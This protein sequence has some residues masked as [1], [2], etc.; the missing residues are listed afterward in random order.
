VQ[1][2]PV[3]CVAATRTCFRARPVARQSHE[4]RSAARG[5]ASATMAWCVPTCPAATHK[6]LSVNVPDLVSTHFVVVEYRKFDFESLRLYLSIYLSTCLS[7]YIY[8]FLPIN[9]PI[10]LHTY[11]YIYHTAP[12]SCRQV[13]RPSHESRSAARARRALQGDGAFKR[14]LKLLIKRSTGHTHTPTE[15]NTPN[16][17]HTHTHTTRTTPHTPKRTPPTNTQQRSKVAR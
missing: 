11:L 9:R 15:N 14:A 4:S 13:A 3:S 2:C 10:H 5:K 6:L 8:T 12:F 1:I 16:T 7:L 17:T